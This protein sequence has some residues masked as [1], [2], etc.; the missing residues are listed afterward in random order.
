MARRRVEDERFAYFA[1][2]SIVFLDL[3]DAVFRGYEGDDQL[4]GA[5]RPDDTRPVR[6]APPRDRP[7]RAAEGLLPARRRR[8]RRPPALPRRRPA[9]A[10]G[11]PPLGDARAGLRRDRHVLRGL[12]VRLVERLRAARGPAA[13]TP[14]RLPAGRLDRR[15]PSPTSPTSSSARSSASTCTRARSSG[16]STARARW[17][18]PSGRT[19]GRSPSSAR[20]TE[21][22]SGTGSP[23]ASDAMTP[24]EARP[25]PVVGAVDRRG[26][27]AVL[28]A[29]HPHPDRCSCRRT[30]CAAT[31]TSS[32]CGSTA[33]RS[34]GLPARLRPEPLVPAG[35]GLH[36]GRPRGDRSRPSRP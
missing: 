33:S 29:R 12:P 11:G 27:V 2:A 3:P 10:P 23:A 35:H 6:P 26:C 4:L 20:S 1:E 18:M 25:R 31:S 32:S 13:R 7:A 34:N 16:C 9:P 8:S 21:P 15:R 24:A 14:R 5:P 17:P 30:A 22:R 36:L 19:D 28:V